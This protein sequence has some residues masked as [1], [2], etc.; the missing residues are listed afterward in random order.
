MLRNSR[1]V[2]D[3]FI[4]QWNNTM[5]KELTI[6]CKECDSMMCVCRGPLDDMVEESPPRTLKRSY[7]ARGQPRFP[8][9]EDEDP[10]NEDD[11]ED[12]EV[13]Q[14]NANYQKK[15][16]QTLLCSEQYNHE[17]DLRAYFEEFGLS[18]QQQIA[19]CRTWAN[20]LTQKLRSSGKMAAPRI[21]K[22]K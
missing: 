21:A 12:E 4:Q 19:I 10:I 17:P 18:A 2:Q 3:W 14:N 1:G 9:E 20:Y 6:P 5:S 7:A 8:S 15:F 16:K 13:V 11:F 22:K